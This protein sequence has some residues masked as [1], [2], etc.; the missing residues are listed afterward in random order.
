MTTSTNQTFSTPAPDAI[1]RSVDLVQSATRRTVG[2]L[3]GGYRQDV[4]SAVAAVA[5]LRREAG[6]DPHASPTAWGLD[7]LEDL[8]FLRNAEQETEQDRRGDQ[9]APQHFS[10]RARQK[11]EERQAREE[12]AVHLA[13]TLWA[14]HQQSIRDTPMHQTNWPLGRAVRRLAHGMTGT[15]DQLEPAD[16]GKASSESGRPPV[17]DASETIRKRFVRI[18]TSTD[19]DTLSWRL[20]Q[21]VLLLRTARIPL[22]YGYLAGQLLLWQSDPLQD[23]V[24]RAWGREFHLAYARQPSA[25]DTKAE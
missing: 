13:V 14:L 24:R 4:A 16:T 3:Q 12:R 19:F 18:G 2:R 15:H 5:R 23:G 1:D 17:E 21:M 6:R 22:D 9:A 20:R 10:A 8:S 25:D 7:D 11:E